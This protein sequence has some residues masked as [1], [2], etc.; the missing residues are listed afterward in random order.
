MRQILF[1]SLPMHAPE[2]LVLVVF[3]VF[4][5]VSRVALTIGSCR[6]ALGLDGRGRLSLRNPWTGEGAGRDAADQ[7]SGSLRFRL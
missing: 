1:N 4:S 5:R 7:F 2:K 3:S 6:A